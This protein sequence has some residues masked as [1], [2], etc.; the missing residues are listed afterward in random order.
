MY[1]NDD[2][3]LE[4]PHEVSGTTRIRWCLLL[5]D[6]Y[7][8]LYLSLDWSYTTVKQS[9]WDHLFASETEDTHYVGWTQVIKTSVVEIVLM[10]TVPQKPNK[11]LMLTQ[12]T[13]LS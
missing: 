12:T 6:H 2:M 5:D 4:A 13:G 3:Y 8:S 11:S 1:N 9:L 10:T 7:W